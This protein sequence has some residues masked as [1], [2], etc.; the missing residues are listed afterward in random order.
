VICLKRKLKISGIAIFGLFLC[1]AMIRTGNADWRT[2]DRSSSGIA[3]APAQHPEAVIQVYGA[4][5]FGWRG[6]MAVHTWI[7]IK[8]KNADHYIVHQV[9]GWRK[10]RNLSVVVSEQDYPDRYWYGNEPDLYVDIRGNDA[11]AIMDKLHAAI[12]SYPHA[13][14]YTMFPGPNSNTFTSYVGRQVPELRLDLP[15]TAIGKDFLSGN[16]FL[17]DATS[18]TGKQFS[19]Y[20]LLGLTLAGEEGLEV[21]LLGLNFGINP[22][23]LSLR[24]P[25]IGILEPVGEN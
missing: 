13:D 20:G 17:D 16:M 18:G 5:T 7:S 14:D 8:A 3:P 21:N 24:L 23:K 10:R 19:I 2:A 6:V 1:I 4:R 12:A 25:G 9:V 22:F 11:E 15:P